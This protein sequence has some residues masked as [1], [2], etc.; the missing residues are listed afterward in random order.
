LL[1][2]KDDYDT[3]DDN[4]Y[5]DDFDDDVWVVT[6]PV[7]RL[8]VTETDFEVGRN[9]CQM[10]NYVETNLNCIVYCFKKLIWML[11]FVCLIW[12]LTYGPILDVMS[13]YSKNFLKPILFLYKIEKIWFTTQ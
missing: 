4:D 2:A 5:D 9:Q 10:P 1:N 3:D 7:A 8:K 13:S 11:I 6:Y 12:T